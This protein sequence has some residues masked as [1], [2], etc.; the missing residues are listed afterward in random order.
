MKKTI[1]LIIIITLLSAFSC[2]A[3]S[4]PDWAVTEVGSAIDAGYVPAEIQSDYNAPIKRGEFARI[5][6][7]FLRRELG[8]SPDEFMDK[9]NSLFD[10]VAFSDTAD[11]SVILAARCGIVYGYGDNTFAPEKPI[12]REE[13]AAM[14][15]RVYNLYGNIYSYSNINYQDNAL[16]ADWA[17]SDVKF[18]VEK[19]VMKGISDTHFD[20][21]GTY[22]R[23]QAI[24]TFWRLD[25]DADWENHNQTAKI[26]RKMT[27]ELAERELLQNTSIISLIEKY[28]TPYGT[29]YHTVMGGMMH[30]PGYG[31]TLIDDNGQTYTLTE[32]VP[33]DYWWGHIPEIKNINFYP[34]RTHF[35]FEVSFE[36]DLSADGREIHKAGTFYFEANLV[37]KKTKL[38][39]FIPRDNQ[40]ILEMAVQEYLEKANVIERYDTGAYGVLLYVKTDMGFETDVDDRYCLVLIGND[41]KSHN[42]PSGPV[43]SRYGQLPPLS[44]ITLSEY[45]SVVSYE[46]V[47]TWEDIAASPEIKEAGT[48]FATVNLI[49]LESYTK[50]ITTN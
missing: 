41:G 29:V 4:L 14:L 2:Y 11:E 9:V 45:N 36:E 43:I 21:K 12:T 10:T 31:L 20:P 8:Y 48:Y 3:S 33:Y 28:E 6:V 50:F 47:Y 16:I 32:G 13:A 19:G 35:S 24:V 37:Q 30:S 26:R 7:E 27:R 15:A 5:A 22:T 46:R 38:V 49:T 1:S 17:I 39:N 25:G 44:N 23:A 34:E 42:L 18:C 40:S